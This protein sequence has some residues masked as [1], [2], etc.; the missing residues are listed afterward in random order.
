MWQSLMK[1][2]CGPYTKDHPF[3]HS[4]A[5]RTLLQGPAEVLT[6]PP[7]S[8]LVSTVSPEVTI[9][10]TWCTLFA[11]QER[12]LSIGVYLALLECLWEHRISS[13]SNFA[14]SETL[15]NHTFMPSSSRLEPLGTFQSHHINNIYSSCPELPFHQPCLKSL[16]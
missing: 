7:L 4:H 3:S 15:K 14:D 13:L 9:S 12:G 16:L 11:W 5:H 10:G 1:I 2:G 6:H 8:T